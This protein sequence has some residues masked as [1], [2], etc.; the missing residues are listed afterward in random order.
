MRS[1]AM[2]LALAALVWCCIMMR[3]ALNAAGQRHTPVTVTRLYAGG[4]GQ[5]HAEQIDVKL[6]PNAALERYEQSETMKAT[7]LQF[8]RWSPGYM[9]DWHTAPKRQYVITLSGRGEIELIGGQKIRSEPGKVVLAED[10]TGKGHITRTLGTEDWITLAV[11][12]AED[13]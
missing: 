12:L 11:P 8:R 1:I 10:L 4:D 3:N 2:G 9:N 13:K 7:G 6:A 5:T